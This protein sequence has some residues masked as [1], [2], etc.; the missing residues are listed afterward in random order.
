MTEELA[1]TVHSEFAR[2]TIEE[3]H[4][5]AVAR[6]RLRKILEGCIQQPGEM[7]RAALLHAFREFRERLLEHMETEEEDGF[8]LPLLEVRPDLHTRIEELL[9]EHN[10]LR[11]EM[12]QTVA[13]LDRHTEFSSPIMDIVLRIADMLDVIEAHERTENALVLETFCQDVGSKD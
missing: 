3:H 11:M 6:S 1:A 12:D 8:M 2:E 5:L 4:R 13:I 9:R 7:N 10:R